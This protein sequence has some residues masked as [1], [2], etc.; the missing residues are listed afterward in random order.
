M[1]VSMSGRWVGDG[2]EANE[3]SEIQSR[4]QRHL[5]QSI[6]RLM[7]PRAQSVPDSSPGCHYHPESMVEPCSPRHFYFCYLIRNR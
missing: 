7:I 1:S 6:S 3:V 2:H 5:L 4:V